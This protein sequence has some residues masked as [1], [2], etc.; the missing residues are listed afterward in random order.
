[1]K[2]Q[3]LIIGAGISGMMAALRLAEKGA[4][5]RLMSFLPAGRSDS[6][7]IRS[8]LAAALKEEDSSAIHLQDTI[9]AGDYLANQELPRLMCEQAGQLVKFIER[10]GVPFNRSSEGYLETRS[11]GGGSHDRTVFAEAET[12]A[13][14]V[15]FLD[16]QLGRLEKEK[17]L[18]RLEGWEFVSSIL[19]SKGVCRGVVAINQRTQEAKSFPSEV[20]IFCTGG[21]GRLF[22]KTTQSLFSTG[23][24][25]SILYQ[26][27]AAYANEPRHQKDWRAPPFVPNLKHIQRPHQP[28][29]VLQRGW[30]KEYCLRDSPPHGS[31]TGPPPQQIFPGDSCDADYLSII[32]PGNKTDRDKRE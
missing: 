22:G 18:E 10:L 20:V 2:P 6:T 32:L 8:G 17:G 24:A 28:P 27:G 11:T 3:C 31:D 13:H 19:D 23:S 21:T 4:S 25:A 9:K 7:C 15:R 29:G 5:V 30:I 26:Q 16:G 1:M 12:G 14:V